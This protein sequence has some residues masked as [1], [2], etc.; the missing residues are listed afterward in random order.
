M[1]EVPRWRLIGD[2]FDLCRCRV[3][4]GCTFAQPPDEGRCDAI[5][6]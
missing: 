6:A 2:W 3:T 4:C 1:A 5:L